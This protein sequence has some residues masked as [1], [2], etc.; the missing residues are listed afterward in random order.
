MRKVIIALCAQAV[1]FGSVAVA[2]PVLDYKC[3]GYRTF[4]GQVTLDRDPEPRLRGVDNTYFGF[5]S[6]RPDPSGPTAGLVMMLLG[7]NRFERDLNRICFAWGLAIGDEIGQSISSSI[8]S[9]EKCSGYTS[10]NGA[11]MTIVGNGVAGSLSCEM[12]IRN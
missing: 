6:F 5:A 3:T 4:S 9:D 2:D 12:R 7:R 10:K 1:L 11:L 8:S